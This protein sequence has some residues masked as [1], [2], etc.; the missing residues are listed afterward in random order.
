MFVLSSVGHL[1]HTHARACVSLTKSR[2]CA[3]CRKPIAVAPS[4]RP[5]W[6]SHRCCRCRR[7]GARIT[8]I[9]AALRRD[10]RSGVSPRI[11]LAPIGPATFRAARARA[12][13]LRL[14]T[15]L[16]RGGLA[17]CR[18]SLCRDRLSGCGS[19]P[20]AGALCQPPCQPSPALARG[21]FSCWEGLGDEGAGALHESSEAR[22]SLLQAR[23][24]FRTA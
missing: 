12:R 16:G 14:R 3:T 23:A 18:R 20:S 1:F 19:S 6:R 5:T 7:R 17:R 8:R 4:I 22:L 13:H 9:R 24:P 21:A 11:S 10:R 2:T 15:R